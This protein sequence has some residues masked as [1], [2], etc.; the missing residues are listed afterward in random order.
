M[1]QLGSAAALGAVGRRF[2]SCRPE[3]FQF[4]SISAFQDLSA[5]C[6]ESANLLRVLTGGTHFDLA[7]GL[8]LASDV[9]K[10]NLPIETHYLI[11]R[12]RQLLRDGSLKVE[13][14]AI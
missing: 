2:K 10:A 12:K 11:L 1:A 8:R 5:N 6:R 7:G 4:G 13:S 9:R 3:G 14:N